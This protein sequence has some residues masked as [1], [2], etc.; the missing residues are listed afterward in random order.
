MIQSDHDDLSSQATY[1]INAL[2][3]SEQ[4]VNAFNLPVTCR[5]FAEM[6]LC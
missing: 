1:T 2:L 3:L 5:Q 6:R 4:G